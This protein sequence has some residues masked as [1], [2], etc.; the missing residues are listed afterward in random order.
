MRQEIENWLA[1]KTSKAYSRISSLVSPSSTGLSWLSIYLIAFYHPQK[2]GLVSSSDDPPVEVG[3][4][5]AATIN[6][7]DTKTIG[8]TTVHIVSIDLN[9][10]A[11]QRAGNDTIGAFR[12]AAGQAAGYEPVAA[13]AASVGQW[14][15]RDRFALR[16]RDCCR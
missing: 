7:S 2:T 3:L 6:V 16:N 15:A 12:S 1:A 9:T 14:A 8:V 4:P 13:L 11:R 10:S 5:K